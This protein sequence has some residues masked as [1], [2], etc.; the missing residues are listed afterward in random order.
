MRREMIGVALALLSLA[1]AAP[2][3][4]QPIRLK[5]GHVLGESA[6]QFFGEGYEKA[7]FSAC[8]AG[9]FKSLNLPSKRK[10]KDYCMGLVDA[11]QQAT[12]GKR[13]EYK[14]SGDVSELRDDTFTFDDG[15]L[16]K[17]ELRFSAPSAEFS[18]RGQSFEKLFAE[19]KQSYGPPTSETS[20]PI[21]DTYGARYIAHRE[22]WLTPQ[23]AILITEKAGPGGSTTLAALKRA[24]YDR[25]VADAAKAVNPLQ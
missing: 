16:V 7:A 17:A 12:S 5:G 25:A 13:S 19:T 10:L 9:D 21:Q 3:Q 18:Y 23:T 11:R 15:R 4:D 2:A 6:E 8:Q 24:E 14:G 1:S 20:E 22:V